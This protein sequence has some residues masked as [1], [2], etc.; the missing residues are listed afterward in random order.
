MAWPEIYICH[1]GHEYDKVFSE[2][3]EAYLT[4]SGVRCQLI[5][6]DKNQLDI[7]LRPCL[8][9]PNAVVVGYN[10]QLD[11][12]YIDGKSF[13][14]EAARKKIPVIQWILDHPASRW[15]EF[16]R[17]AIRYSAFLLNTTYE[18]Q[19]FLRF[20]EPGANTRVMGGV[21]PSKRSR[22]TQ[23][24]R[25]TFLTRPETC[26]IALG[27]R[28]LGR[29]IE[30]TQAEIAAL[31]VNLSKVINSSVDAAKYDLENPLE[32]H[33]LENLDQHGVVLD[34]DAFNYCFRLLEDCVQALRR[35]EIFAEARRYTVCVQSD[36]AAAAYVQG[37]AAKFSSNV[38]MQSTLVGMQNY[39][40]ILS[41]SPIN[42]LIHDRTMNAL[43]AGCVPIIEDNMIHRRVFEHGKNALMFRY[44]DSSLADCLEVV[45]NKP[46]LA[47]AIAEEAFSLRDDPR[48]FDAKFHNI[49]EVAL[50]QLENLHPISGT[51]D[52]RRE[53]FARLRDHDAV[54]LQNYR[55]QEIKYLREL[56]DEAVGRD[57]RIAELEQRLLELE[58]Q[59]KECISSVS[60]RVT[61]P[62]RAALAHLSPNHVRL[63]RRTIKLCYW[64]MTP[65]RL[66]NR[67]K[68]M[69]SKSRDQ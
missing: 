21:G 9:N 13:V 51:A 60:W 52:K 42:D 12:S 32:V 16:N 50:A 19:Y 8:E 36:D 11:H 47:W 26:L 44:G 25:E 40:S 29:S 37:G 69:R 17:S 7:N 54:A 62:L 46:K 15:S 6:L 2:N 20:C 41:V 30:E 59:L 33:L 58:Q 53:K 45:C 5:E 55:R 65:H 23:L 68:L 31:D 38:N 64:A 27:F 63:L 18:Q 14:I 24:S 22:I 67:L 39:Q 57:N 61:S 35:T 4:S 48:V 49:I 34:D 56:E 43:N 66:P 28:R 3:L 1:Y 10:S